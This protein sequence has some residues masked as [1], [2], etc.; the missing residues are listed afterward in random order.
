MGDVFSCV[1]II[2]GQ[3]FLSIRIFISVICDN[4][5]YFMMEK[6]D[7]SLYTSPLSLKRA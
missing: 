4:L 1:I 3:K 6:K 5:C 7:I 2:R